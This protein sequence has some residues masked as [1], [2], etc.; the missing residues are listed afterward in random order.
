MIVA[1]IVTFNPAE[2]PDRLVE[3]LR[4]SCEVVLVD[5]STEPRAANLVRNAAQ[6]HGSARITMGCNA[7]IAEAQNAGLRHAR[8]LGCDAVVFFDQDSLIDDEAVRGL[9][10]AL[11]QNPPAVF[12]LE[13]G[14]HG[15]RSSTSRPI[16][17]LM[18]SGS[19]CRLEVFD[20]VGDFEGDLFIDC[21][22]FEWGWRCRA[23]RVPL[24][25]IRAGEFQ[26]RLGRAQIG[27]PFLRAHIDSPVRLYYQYRNI[28]VMLGRG[29][30]PFAWKLAQ[31]ARSLSKL[32]GM[33]IWTTDRRSR[34]SMV[35]RGLCDALRGRLGPF[36]EGAGT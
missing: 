29:Y 3:I 25:A 34:L 17:E 19:G 15:V 14:A 11:E 12:S 18:S 7:G 23:H 10:E 9:V 1:V 21:V 35:R 30:V 13:R 5:N 26:H 22:D 4:G 2:A 27:L 28:C 31:T 24:L 20:R 32:L 36:R 16:R 33:V 8:Q 6:R